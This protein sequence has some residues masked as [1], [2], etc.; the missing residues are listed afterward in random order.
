[1]SN[2][3]STPVPLVIGFPQA[4][5]NNTRFVVD[6]KMVKRTATELQCFYIVF[7]VL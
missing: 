3:R 2:L 6:V 4:R 7:I 5:I 1:M